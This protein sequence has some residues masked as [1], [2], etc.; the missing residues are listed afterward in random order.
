[1]KIFLAYLLS[2]FIPFLC[3]AIAL[4]GFMP[5]VLLL[6]RINAEPLYWIEAAII[7]ML[8]CFTAVF[9]SHTVF[10]WLSIKYSIGPIL[11]MVLITIIPNAARIARFRYS[12]EGFIEWGYAIGALYGFILGAL[13]FVWDVSGNFIMFLGSIPLLLLAYGIIL[14]RTKTFPFWNLVSKFP[15]EAYDWFCTDACW[16]IYD[17]PNG[18]TLKPDTDKYNGGFTLYVPKLNRRI[19]IFGRFDSIEQSER[20]FLEKYSKLI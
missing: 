9:L 10:A 15:D 13:F 1:M 11:C 2:A 3:E 20:Q 16:Y 5:F 17:P 8:A 14:S 4:S 7:T 12:K 6:K 19:T 18:Q